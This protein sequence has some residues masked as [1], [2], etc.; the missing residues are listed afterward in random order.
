MM[1]ARRVALDKGGRLRLSRN[2][3]SAAANAAASRSDSVPGSAATMLSAY[4]SS[5]ISSSP[6]R[7]ELRIGLV[8]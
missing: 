7:S 1:R 3:S 2:G 5:F 4:L 6:P 8:W